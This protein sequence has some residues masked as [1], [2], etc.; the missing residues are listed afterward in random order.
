MANAKH[1]PVK[2]DLPGCPLPCCIWSRAVN[3]TMVKLIYVALIGLKSQLN[4]YIITNNA[5]TSSKPL[6]QQSE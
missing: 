6:L 1:I 3:V 4:N 2:L 5:K